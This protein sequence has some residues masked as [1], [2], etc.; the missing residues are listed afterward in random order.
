MGDNLVPSTM[1]CNPVP[2]LVSP[3]VILVQ[4]LTE[5]T[6]ASTEE[7]AAQ[8]QAAQEQPTQ[9]QPAVRQAAVKQATNE[10]AAAA[11]T[12]EWACPQSS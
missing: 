4:A 2:V 11:S 12:E 7:Q 10:T 6:A 9:E 1:G 5:E 8:E 3:K